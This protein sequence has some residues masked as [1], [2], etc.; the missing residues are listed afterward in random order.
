MSRRGDS[1]LFA[2]LGSRLWLDGVNPIDAKSHWNPTGELRI[3]PRR[4]RRVLLW[5]KNLQ[6]DWL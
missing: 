5:C 2:H 3:H 4:L 1:G 6:L